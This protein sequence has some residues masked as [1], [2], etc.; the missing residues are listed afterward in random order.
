MIRGAF[1]CGCFSPF[2]PSS[3]TSPSDR[4]AEEPPRGC[5]SWRTTL[6]AYTQD[7]NDPRCILLRMLLPVP[8]QLGDVALR[9]GDGRTPA[10]LLVVEDDANCVHTGSQ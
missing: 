10:R 5:L 3:A 2:P 7:P 1:C 4:D 8:S 6:T 9:S